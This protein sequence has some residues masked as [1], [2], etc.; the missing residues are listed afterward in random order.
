MEYMLFVCTD[1]SAPPY[2]AAED[3]IEEWVSELESRDAHRH[4]DRLR[5]IEVAARHSMARFGK[6]EIRPVWPIDF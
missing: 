4:G 2:L 3:N 1:P 5:P 6:I